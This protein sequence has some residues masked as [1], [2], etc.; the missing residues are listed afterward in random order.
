MKKIVALS[1]IKRSLLGLSLLLLQFVVYYVA[2]G[3]VVAKTGNFLT[4]LDSKIPFFPEFIYVYFSLYLMFIVYFGYF[5]QYFEKREVWTKLIPAIVTMLL[6]AFVFF[7]VVPSSYP[8]P[9][10]M[11]FL[12][13]NSL[14]KKMIVFL[15]KTDPP[16]NTT[17]SLHVAS[18]FLL[19]LISYDKSR[20]FGV[21]FTGWSLLIMAST[22]FVKQHYVID[23]ISGILLALFC[24]FVVYQRMYWILKWRRK[25]EQKHGNT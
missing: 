22:L 3:S 18:S 14:T 23:V 11:D 16:N 1:F 7:I 17:P 8:R 19:A 15:Y 4:I 13:T 20:A 5:L 2:S 12:E 10:I 21:V 6:V 25:Y 24:W 9:I